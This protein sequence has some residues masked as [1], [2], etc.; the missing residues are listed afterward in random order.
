[1]N[2]DTEYVKGHWYADKGGSLHVACRIS[3]K[4]CACWGNPNVGG[5]CLTKTG[6]CNGDILFHDGGGC[7]WGDY[8]GDIMMY[9]HSNNCELCE[10]NMIEEEEEE[11][12]YRVLKFRNG[13]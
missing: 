8:S 13:V 11:T 1:M 6:R 9:K 3:N 2:P 12:E 4:K 10:E 7:G 5:K